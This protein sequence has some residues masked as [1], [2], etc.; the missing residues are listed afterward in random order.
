MPDNNFEKGYLRFES[1]FA[2]TYSLDSQYWG[3]GYLAFS[4]KEKR[5]E[6]AND[7]GALRSVLS[8]QCS[9]FKDYEGPLMEVNL[10]GKPDENT[11]SELSIERQ[12]AGFFF[13]QWTLLTV[14]SMSKNPCNLNCYYHKAETQS[15]RGTHKGKLKFY[16]VICPDHRLHVFITCGG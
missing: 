11:F 16:E 7:I 8:G 2:P 12:G 1:G 5:F 4:N 15:C 13:Q 3:D 10:W 6:K 14:N 9:G